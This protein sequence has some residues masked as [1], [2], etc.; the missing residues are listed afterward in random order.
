MLEITD[1]LIISLEYISSIDSSV[2]G[3][4]QRDDW[5]KLIKNEEDKFVTLATPWLTISMTNGDKHQVRGLKDIYLFLDNPA[6]NKRRTWNSL[7][8]KVKSYLARDDEFYY[9]SE[10]DREYLT[11]VI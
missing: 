8:S 3:E 2:D 6:V 1:S 5:N 4:T 10:E 7:V 9:L 11:K